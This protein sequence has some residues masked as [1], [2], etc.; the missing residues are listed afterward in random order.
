LTE[1]TQIVRFDRD[2]RYPQSLPDEAVDVL[3][4]IV[5]GKLVEVVDKLLDDLLD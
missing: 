5:Q 3:S 2:R 1:K 4:A